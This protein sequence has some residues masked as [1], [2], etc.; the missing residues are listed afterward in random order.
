MRAVPPSGIEPEPP[1]LQPGAQTIYARVGEITRTAEDRESSSGGLWGARNGAHVIHLFNCQGSFATSPIDRGHTLG[2]T[3]A[4]RGRSSTGPRSRTW[5]WTGQSRLSCRLDQSG[6]SQRGAPRDRTWRA[7]ESIGFTD[8]SASLA[9]YRSRN[10]RPRLRSRVQR[11]S[12]ST[13]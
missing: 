4:F 11:R 2:V 9:G 10:W 13:R 3:A 5:I 12:P 6:I 1:G 8:R 7:F